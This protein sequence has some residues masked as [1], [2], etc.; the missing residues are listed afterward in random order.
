[1][2]TRK[3]LAAQKMRNLAHDSRNLSSARRSLMKTWFSP[4]LQ[5]WKWYVFQ[6]FVCDHTTL[7]E[8]CRFF[9][10][11]SKMSLTLYY[12]AS[13]RISGKLI[14]FATKFADS[15]WIHWDRG[16]SRRQS[17]TYP[18]THLDDYIKIP[19]PGDRNWSTNSQCIRVDATNKP[20]V[21]ANSSGEEVGQRCTSSLVPRTFTELP[22]NHCEGILGVSK[23]RHFFRRTLVPLAD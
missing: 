9:L 1:M 7:L 21:E 10:L 19:N 6:V 11:L 16:Y 13:F 2:K 23:W 17:K 8:E 15:S 3:R 5:C 22:N 14:N 12:P 20:G 18:R 4:P